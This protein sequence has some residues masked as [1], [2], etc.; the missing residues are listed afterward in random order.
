ML[1]VGLAMPGPFDV[2][3]MSFVG[4]TTLEGWQGVPIRDHLAAMT[5]LPTFIESDHACAAVG[6]RLYGIGRNVW[7]FIIF[8]PA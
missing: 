1:G 3:S 8:I 6:E 5:G 7:D 2:E 4:P